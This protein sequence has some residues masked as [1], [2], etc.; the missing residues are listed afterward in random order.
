MRA[1]IQR[2]EEASVEVNGEV[3]ASIG[4][5]F[6]ILLGVREDDTDD[7]VNYLAKKIANLRVFEDEQGKMNL[8]PRSVEAQFLVVSQFT[9]YAD[10]RRGNRPSFT[11]AAGPEKGE[12]MYRK[13]LAKLKEISG[14]E[15]KE[16]VFG[17][18][19]KVKLT[20][21]GPV[22]IIIDSKNIAK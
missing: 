21:D 5:G 1:V 15:V 20:N 10:T 17:A 13:F 11:E 19:M 9:L 14:L 12:K 2:V 16:G 6:L 22:T 8:S 18:R 4:R 3:I 7:D